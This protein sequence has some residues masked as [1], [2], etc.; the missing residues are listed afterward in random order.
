MVALLC[1]ATYL[2]L[3]ALSFLTLCCDPARLTLA[4][5]QLMIN[6]TA[7]DGILGLARWC[8]VG[9]FAYTTPG[10]GF[11]MLSAYDYQSSQPDSLEA[12]SHKYVADA[13][14]GLQPQDNAQPGGPTVLMTRLRNFFTM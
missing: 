13:V 11:F 5:R 6:D 2:A 14:G 12:Q 7:A 1:A 8:F 10:I 9:F 3:A 4:Q